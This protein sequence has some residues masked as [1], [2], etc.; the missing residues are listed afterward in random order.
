MKKILPLLCLMFGLFTLPT[1]SQPNP[2]KFGITFSTTAH[3]DIAEQIPTVTR[4]DAKTISYT[5]PDYL[6]GY[7]LLRVLYRYLRAD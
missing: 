3:A 5:T 1:L 2:Y 6:Q 4:H 7:R